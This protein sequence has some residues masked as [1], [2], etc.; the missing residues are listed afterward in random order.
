M[1]TT[2][3]T[4]TFDIIFPL[5]ARAIKKSCQSPS[6]FVSSR[7]ITRW[8]LKDANG[9]KLVVAAQRKRLK[10]ASLERVAGNMTGWFSQRWT[11]NDEKWKSLF[12]LFDRRQDG[13]RWSYTPIT[14]ARDVDVILEGA[15][16]QR[17][18]NVYERSSLARLKCIARY[19]TKCDLCGFSFSVKYG[20][21]FDGIILVH[22]LH[23]LGEIGEKHTVDPIKDL[24][25]VCANCHIVL[26]TRTPAYSISELRSFLRRGRKGQ[27]AKGT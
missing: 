13:P 7:E 15:I 23:P 27:H 8:L 26:H 18:V 21:A 6:T 9:R 25:P 5:I 3:T 17:S 10:K 24:R 11:A 14:G 2:H 12:E 16:V 4:F 1:N 20:K 22:H 19:G